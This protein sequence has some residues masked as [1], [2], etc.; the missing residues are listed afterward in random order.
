[1]FAA[2]KAA[3]PPASALVRSAKLT[4]NR[5]MN[6]HLSKKPM[7]SSISQPFYVR[8]LRFFRLTSRAS[9]AALAVSA[10]SAG[11]LVSAPAH[12]ADDAA[13]PAA[14]APVASEPA[15]VA[16]PAPAVSAVPAGPR[17]SASNLQQAFNYMDANHDGKLSREE[18]AGF[19]GVA[20]Y[21]DRADTNHDHF[22]SREEFERAMN[23][24]KPQ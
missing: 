7:T 9:V 14:T 5:G 21:F 24:V 16:T 11:L 3:K 15:A 12:S 2:G 6:A 13:A 18:A 17:Y 23:Y 22:L 4:F 8:F 10:A 1:M 19:R 20:K